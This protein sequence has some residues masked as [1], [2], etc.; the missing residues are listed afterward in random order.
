MFTCLLIPQMLNVTYNVSYTTMT[1]NSCERVLISVDFI[2]L[3]YISFPFIIV[4]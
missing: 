3:Y 2:A 4:L 1:L